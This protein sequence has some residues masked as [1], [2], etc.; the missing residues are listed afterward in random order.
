MKE[1]LEAYNAVYQLDEVSFTNVGGMGATRFNV[2]APEKKKEEPKAQEPQATE[3]KPAETKPA[4]TSAMDQWAA[5]NPKLAAAAAEKARI[6][7]TNQTDNPLIDAEMRAK[8]PAPT[9]NQD[10][11]FQSTMKSGQYGDQGHQSLTQNKYVTKVAEPSTST[12]KPAPPSPPAMTA[13]ANQAISSL[14]QSAK[15]KKAQE[16]INMNKWFTNPPKNQMNSYDYGNIDPNQLTS[17]LDAYQQ[18]YKEQVGVPMKPG[19]SEG[20]ALERVS[21]G[22][23][24]SKDVV[25]K[26]GLEKAHYEPE[27]EVIDEAGDDPCWKGYTQ[28]GMKKKGGREVPN[29]VP[30]KGVPKAKGYKKEEVEQIDEIAP[31]IAGGLALGGAALAGAAINRAKKAAQSGVD[32]AK[33]GQKVSNPQGISGAAYGIQKRNQANAEAMKLLRQSYEPEGEVVEA[34]DVILDHL[35]SE[36]FATTVENAE[37][38][39]SVMSDEWMRDI[40]SENQGMLKFTYKPGRSFSL[41]GEGSGTSGG[42]DYRAG[43]DVTR[44]SAGR[45]VT[46]STVSQ[47]VQQAAV[48][49]GTTGET[50]RPVGARTGVTGYAN[51]SGGFRTGAAPQQP[52]PNQTTDPTKT[53]PKTNPK[54]DPKTDPKNKVKTDPRTGK[55]IVPGVDTGRPVETKRPLETEKPLE[56]GKPAETALSQAQRGVRPTM[57]GV[58]R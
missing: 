50:S 11:N 18:V 22:K 10:P 38:I 34:Y 29:C 20:E 21:G 43:L 53:N 15:A 45:E 1:L 6:R 31:L 35:M 4:S 39:M 37:K 41:G 51:V 23:I 46:P 57:P 56:T 12:A 27:G 24:K 7:G 33:K 49:P 14:E 16:P 9:K 48:Q 8:M 13:A 32:A 44:Y 52:Q 19:E 28:V 58:G 47:G 30:S 25:S 3:T 54:T 2:T 42:T 17:L 40:I 55:P 36:G 26:K 5:A